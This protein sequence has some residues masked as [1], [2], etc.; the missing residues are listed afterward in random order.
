MP[1]SSAKTLDLAGHIIYLEMIQEVS[2]GEINTIVQPMVF[3]SHTNEL[4][5]PELA[6]ADTDPTKNHQYNG[7]SPPLIT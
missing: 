7:A 2:E 6:N 4:E 5:I 3:F 1:S